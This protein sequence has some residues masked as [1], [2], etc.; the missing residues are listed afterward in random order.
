LAISDW[1][2][3]SRAV[4]R[5]TENEVARITVQHGALRT[6]LRRV[7]TNSWSFAPGSQGV[8]NNGAVEDAVKR[9]GQ[10]DASAWIA[11]G[12]AEAADYGFGATNRTVHV[13]LK[14]GTRHEVEFGGMS[15]DNY[16][17]ARVRIGEQSWT[18]EFP[19][20]VSELIKFAIPLPAGKP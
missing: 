4:W 7:G 1:Q 11:R 9:L 5:F 10:L 19:I 2:L 3:R 8:I 13:E 20:V 12:D 15:A 18:F 6:E 16:P 17:Y 14:D